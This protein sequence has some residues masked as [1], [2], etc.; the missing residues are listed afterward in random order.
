LWE[1]RFGRTVG[2][3]LLIMMEG[4]LHGAAGTQCD[5]HQEGSSASD[6]DLLEA[7]NILPHERV[8]IRNITKDARILIYAI[9]AP[10]GSS[11]IAIN[12]AAARYFQIGDCVI[13]AAFAHTDEAEAR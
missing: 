8:E 4:K 2:L 3:W 10:R 6:I 9:E 12:G 11:T 5:R 13:T 7:A 1:A